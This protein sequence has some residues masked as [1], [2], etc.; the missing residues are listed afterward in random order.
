ME[1]KAIQKL[2]AS[3]GFVLLANCAGPLWNCHLAFEG[4]QLKKTLIKPLGSSLMGRRLLNG[5]GLVLLV[6]NSRQSWW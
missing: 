2:Q 6:R 3:R 1:S 4:Q 5:E